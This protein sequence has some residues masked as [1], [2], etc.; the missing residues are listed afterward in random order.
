[1]KF[2]KASSIVAACVDWLWHLRVPVG[3]F[4]LLG[5]R[6]GIGKSLTLIDLAA[7]ITPRHVERHL[8]R[9]A[10]ERDD[11]GVG[12][13]LGSYH[14]AAPNGVQ[15]RFSRVSSVS[16]V[17]TVSGLAELSLPKDLDGLKQNLLSRSDAD[18]VVLF[19]MDPLLSTLEGRLDTHKDAEVRTAL[20]PLVALADDT[21]VSIMGS[22][23]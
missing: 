21:G 12:R 6:E 16:K 1:V 11:I 3:M 22:S 10:S 13:Q 19:V 14:C 4:G 15:R 2:T 8:F 20:H 5:G 18:R 23:M 7:Q 9:Q 17:E